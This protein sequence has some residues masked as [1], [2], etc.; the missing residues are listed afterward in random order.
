MAPQWCQDG[1]RMA[2]G[3]RHGGVALSPDRREAVARPSSGCTSSGCSRARYLPEARS[4]APKGCLGLLQM[5]P[6]Q[7]PLPVG[8]GRPK[9]AAKRDA[10]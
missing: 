1:A 4:A 7:T 6:S 3:W 5:T 2:P 8:S 9:R 10:E